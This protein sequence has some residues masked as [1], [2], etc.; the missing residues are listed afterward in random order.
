M[1]VVR[2]HLSRDTKT[3]ATAIYEV[4]WKLTN[5]R[6]FWNHLNE[7]H[8]AVKEPFSLEFYS[9]G[10]SIFACIVGNKPTV[11]L[12]VSGIY[13][14][15][16]DIEVSV[17]DDYTHAT[18]KE[19]TVVAGNDMFL[20]R[21]DIYPIQSFRDFAWGSLSPV[22]E[23]L[24][25]TDSRDR[26]LVQVIINPIKDSA[27]LH[28]RL[29]VARRVQDVIS[30]IT[31]PRSLFGHDANNKTDELVDTK[32]ASRLFWVNYRITAFGEPW[33]NGDK[34][35]MKATKARL[36]RNV[37]NVANSAKFLNTLNENTLD[38]HPVVIGKTQLV[39]AQERRFDKP[40]RLSGLEVATLWY[41]PTPG[42]LPNTT[43]VLSRKVP[44]PKNLPSASRDS[45]AVMFGETNFRGMNIP[46]G[47][48][49]PDRR[50]HMY[51]V[52]KS[53]NGKSCFMQLLAHNDMQN[54]YGCAVLDPHGDLV[55]ELLKRLPAHRA[56][57]VVLFDPSDI[58]Y[59]P[60]FNPLLPV[61]PELKGQVCASV[62]DTFKRI[63]SRYWS[64]NMD[65][66]LRY[67]MLALVNVPGASLISLRRMLIEDEYRKQVLAFSSDETILRFWQVEF[68]NKRNTFIEGPIAQLLMKIDEIFSTNMLRNILGQSTSTLNFREIIDSRKILLCKVSKGL[69]GADSAYFI[70][71]LIIW[72][73]YEAAI[74]RAD[75]P[76]ESRQDFYFYIDEFQNFATESFG[77]ILSESRKY[78]LCLTFANQFLGQLPGSIKQSIFGNVGNLVSF[79]VG[80][81]DSGPLAKELKPHVGP[82]DL[83]NL[84]LRQ[85]FVKMTVDDETQEAF[86][87]RTLDL[88]R[89]TANEA[90]I[91]EC[92]ENSRAKYALPLAQ[93]EEQVALA[94]VIS[95]TRR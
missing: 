43:M 83:L 75:I 27:A 10:A 94:E 47:I 18:V 36:T 73:L 39:K 91:K 70:G 34:A 17:L 54:G 58:N 85:F 44:P 82:G 69:L 25:N 26:M 31:R 30:G 46:F 84:P 40:F 35:D 24:S 48:L 74:S 66:V 57:D 93:A 64:E 22:I 15:L 13:A 55:D 4:Q 11:E 49:R 14:Y 76:A 9:N 52:G 20:E 81:E 32:C 29:G 45:S 90:V 42:T 63:L 95:L 79:R 3:L 67:A 61:S 62:V 21:S 88:P 53:G 59:P 51:T 72:K 78:R 89:A 41:P 92:L 12:I 8:E 28:F 60:C 23:S 16:P 7:I 68:E 6:F 19:N 5:A 2:L 80:G 77:E 38:F 87:G 1:H 50:R 86:S 65:L 33:G 56:K 71:S 37:T